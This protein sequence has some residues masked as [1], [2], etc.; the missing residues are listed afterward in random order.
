MKV[1]VAI[2]VLSFVFAR[3][4]FALAQAPGEHPYSLIT[5]AEAWQAVAN[6]LRQRGF[7][8]DELPGIEDVEL[9]VTLPA[10]AGRRLQVSSVC[11][12]AD[13]ARVRF[14]LE[15]RPASACL[16][17]LAYVRGGPEPGSHANAPSCRLENPERVLGPSQHTA[18]SVRAGQ[19]ATAM[20]AAS[21]L[22][23]RAVVTCLDRGAK[24]EIV[25][26]RGQE[27]RVFRARVAGQALVEA[28]PE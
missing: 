14:R 8:A 26:V 22:Q 13:A 28:L 19:R 5:V 2:G 12:N 25:R 4:P 24:G 23:M 16:R 3:W 6:E 17:F 1:I 10:R 27:G 15:C 18:P 21:G 9:P 7:V 20:L 11:W